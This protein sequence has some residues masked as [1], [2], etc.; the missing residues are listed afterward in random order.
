MQQQIRIIW[1]IQFTHVCNWEEIV[2]LATREEII[3][4]GD[5]YIGAPEETEMILDV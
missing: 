5:M 1:L 3:W 4:Q 2:N